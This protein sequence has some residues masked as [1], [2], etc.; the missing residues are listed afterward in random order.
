MLTVKPDINRS[1]T[2]LQTEK[3]E[4]RSAESETQE[5]NN[6]E[7]KQDESDSKGSGT[8]FSYDQLKAKSEN[9]VA[10]INFKRREV[11]HDM[12]SSSKQ[13]II[14]VKSSSYVLDSYVV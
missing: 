4:D 11:R 8:F 14:N 1:T 7:G 13:L 3:L 2:I 5:Y 9:L 12:L 10:G 6:S